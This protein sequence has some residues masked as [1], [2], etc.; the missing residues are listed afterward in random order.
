MILSHMGNLNAD[1]LK[2]SVEK[3]DDTK[4]YKRVKFKWIDIIE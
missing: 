2:L 1:F 3:F 4:N